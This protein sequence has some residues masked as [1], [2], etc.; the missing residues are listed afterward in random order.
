MKLSALLY[1]IIRKELFRAFGMALVFKF[2]SI[3]N[4]NVLKKSVR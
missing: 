4:D 2:L 1:T 3:E